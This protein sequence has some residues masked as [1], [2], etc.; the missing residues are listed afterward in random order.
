MYSHHRIALENNKLFAVLN[1]YTYLQVYS[2]SANGQ[3]GAWEC[4]TDLCDLQ[5]FVPPA[6]DH[7]STPTAPAE[8]TADTMDVDLEPERD[9]E[10]EEEAT[11]VPT[12]PEDDQPQTIDSDS[13]ENPK[14]SASESGAAHK[15]RARKD[16]PQPS[17]NSQDVTSS[18]TTSS[19]PREL[20]RYKRVV[21][22]AISYIMYIRTQ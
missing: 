5:A 12:A 3:F 22:C 6:T 7:G 17:E 9:Q 2:V 14:E 11:R 10:A 15:K 8:R 18:K 21:K 16:R 4:D 20:V 13:E 1:A 19:P